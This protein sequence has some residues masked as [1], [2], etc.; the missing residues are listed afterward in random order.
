L[1]SSVTALN[2]RV[3]ALE[4]QLGLERSALAH[5]QAATIIDAKY[6]EFLCSDWEE[7]KALK[8]GVWVLMKVIEEVET[9]RN[10]PAQEVALDG[11]AA[12][13]LLKSMDDTSFRDIVDRKNEIKRALGCPEAIFAENHAPLKMKF[14]G[15]SKV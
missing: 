4:T 2:S 13:T 5:R 11:R 6:V 7:G 10:G 15:L 8:I 14:S 1:N 9:Q 3:T 12:F